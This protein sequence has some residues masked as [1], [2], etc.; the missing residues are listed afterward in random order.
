MERAPL[1]AVD[2]VLPTM[3]TA[4]RAASL[5]APTA[6]FS[7]KSCTVPCSSCLMPLRSAIALARAPAVGPVDAGAGVVVAAAPV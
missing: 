2:A 3:S 4:S 1:T 6:P 5:M 7:R